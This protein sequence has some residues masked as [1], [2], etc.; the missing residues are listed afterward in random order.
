MTYTTTELEAGN[1]LAS[2]R[3]LKAFTYDGTN[4]MTCELED[5]IRGEPSEVY[6]VPPARK[7]GWEERQ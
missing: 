7:G 4:W 2:D 3:S 1:G 6:T 5:G